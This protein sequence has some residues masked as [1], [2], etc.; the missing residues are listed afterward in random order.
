MSIIDLAQ[1]SGLDIEEV[2]SIEKETNKKPTP[3]VIYKIA[4]ALNLPCGGLME[5]AGLM[6]RRDE[7]LSK[8]AVKFAACSEPSAALSKNERNA[9]Q[10]F[11]GVLAK[12]SGGNV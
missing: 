8:A 7:E 9:L 6:E 2:L 11:V 5:L 4:Q 12:F 10:E 3:R 1:K